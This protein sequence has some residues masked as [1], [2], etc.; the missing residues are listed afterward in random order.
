[1]KK[2][3]R[4]IMMWA[5]LLAAAAGFGWLVLDRLE[6]APHRHSDRGDQTPIP[7][8]VAPIVGGP[9]EW[10]QTFSGT[11]ES[12]SQLIVAPKIGGRIVQLNVELGDRVS[13]GQVVAALD[14]DEYVQAVHLAKAD[15]EVAKA[16]LTEARSALE[17]AARKLQRMERLRERDVASDAEFDTAK[18]EHLGKLAQVEVSKAQV[19]KAE[20]SLETARIRLGYAQVT[21]NWSDGSGDRVVGDRFADE[22]ETVSANEPLISVV[23]LNPVKAVIF[24]TEKDYVH[25]KAGQAAWLMAD[26]YPGERFEARID[27]ISPVFRESSRQANIELR[28]GNP[29]Y[30]L[31]PGMF[32]RVTVS[33]ARVE[34][35]VIVPQQALTERNDHVGVFVVA[36][37][38]RS[39]VWRPVSV[40]IREGDQVQVTGDG[41][42]GR[43]V[44]LGQQLVD[45]GSRITIP[46]DQ[47]KGRS[48]G[49]EASRP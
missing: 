33:L 9:I 3:Q 45:D 46:D 4:Y 20:A 6:T 48:A 5:L 39:V 22:G 43:V 29:K 31:K 17:I 42:V 38:D 35:A 49:S 14:D 8:E 12:P 26:A 40:G 34:N 16:N 24:V 21:A 44:T 32:V 27:R 7:V 47:D 13:R 36:A 30:R 10:R 11:I 28:V 15:L 41:L 19:A 37:D 18:A 23:Q 1:V 2:G 25:L